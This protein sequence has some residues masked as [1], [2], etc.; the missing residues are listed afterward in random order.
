MFSIYWIENLPSANTLKFESSD[1]NIRDP[2][3][4]TSADPSAGGDSQVQPVP[5]VNS[6]TSSH[7]QI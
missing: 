6:P 1:I 2:L 4:D 5:K 3:G 7:Q